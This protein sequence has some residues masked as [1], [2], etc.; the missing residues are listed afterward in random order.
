MK[1]KFVGVDSVG[2][3]RVASPLAGKTRSSFVDRKQSV[4]Y[5]VHEAELIADDA[6]DGIMFFELAGPR[7][8]IFYGPSKIACGI[9]TCGGLCPGLNDVIRSIT[10]ELYQ[11]Y[12]VRKVLGFRYGYKGLTK[13][14]EFPPLLL[15][16]DNVDDIHNLGGTILSS[17][18][19]AQASA[20]MVD[21]LVQNGVSILFAIGGDGTMRGAGAIVEE[22]RKRGLEISVIAIPKTIDNDINY[23]RMSFGFQTAV[24]E[25]KSVIASAHV[26]AKGAPNGVGI[27]KLMGRHS[28]YIA[29]TATLA[30]SDVNYCLIPEVPFRLY[31][32]GGLMDILR[33]RLEKK[34]HAVIV[35]AEGAGQELIPDGPGAQKTDASGNLRLKN[36]GE[37]LKSAIE[38]Y[39]GS[40]KTEVNVKYINPSYIIRSVPANAMDSAYCLMLGQNA[41]HA[42]MAGRTNIVIGHWNSHFIHVPVEM[43]VRTRDKVNPDRRLWKTVMESTCQPD[44]IF[45]N[46]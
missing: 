17:S 23:V 30:N 20:E 11:R 24:E 32:E 4:V 29:A 42:G 13:D 37:F 38:E 9:V 25:S 34:G 43:A 12:G 35:V 2:S 14:T 22:I 16:P 21:A 45:E 1:I 40:I 19:G 44:S 5:N 8:K 18:R 27:V 41:V 39:F 6:S 28:G 7:E 31:G 33:G 26:E 10:I 3:C 36:I 46:R 15:D